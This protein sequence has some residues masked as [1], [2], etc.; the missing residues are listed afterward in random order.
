MSAL[1][2]A[3]LSRSK[4]GNSKTT[5]TFRIRIHLGGA[6]K[7]L[8][9]SGHVGQ[10][11]LSTQIGRC[12]EKNLGVD[13]GPRLS[14]VGPIA[15]TISDDVGVEVLPDGP[16]CPQ[17]NIQPT[18]DNPRV[19]TARRPPASAK[20]KPGPLQ[21]AKKKRKVPVNALA[22]AAAK[23]KLAIRKAAAKHKLHIHNDQPAPK[24]KRLPRKPTTQKKGQQVSSH[25]A[26][27]DDLCDPEWETITKK[28]F[29]AK[30]SMYFSHRSA[31]LA[32]A[33][34]F[35]SVDMKETV[36][37]MSKLPTAPKNTPRLLSVIA[38]GSDGAVITKN[39]GSYV[40]SATLKK[41]WATFLVAYDF[42]PSMVSLICSWSKKKKDQTGHHMQSV[43]C[44]RFVA[45]AIGLS[46][47]YS[48]F[49]VM[50]W[51][52]S[53]AGK[54]EGVEFQGI[55]VYRKLRECLAK[56][57]SEGSLHLWTTYVNQCTK[58][59]EDQGVDNIYK[60]RNGSSVVAKTHTLMHTLHMEVVC[61]RATILSYL[62]WC[63][64]EANKQFKLENPRQDPKTDALEWANLIFAECDIE[65]EVYELCHSLFILFR[66]GVGSVYVNEILMKGF[67]DAVVLASNPVKNFPRGIADWA[68]GAA[69]GDNSV[70]TYAYLKDLLTDLGSVK[71]GRWN[72]GFDK[73]KELEEKL[74]RSRAHHAHFL[75]EQGA[76][77]RPPYWPRQQI[78]GHSVS[79]ETSLL[80]EAEQREKRERPSLEREQ[81]PESIPN[82]DQQMPESN[83]ARITHSLTTEERQEP[84]DG[85][86]PCDGSTTPA[87]QDP[88][89]SPCSLPVGPIADDVAE[90]TAESKTATGTEPMKLRPDETKLDETKLDSAELFKLFH[91]CR[92]ATD[93]QMMDK[94]K[95]VPYVWVNY[96]GKSPLTT[97]RLVMHMSAMEF[98][99]LEKLGQNFH[100]MAYFDRDNECGT[101]HTRIPMQASVVNDNYVVLRGGDQKF[102]DFFA[103]ESAP[104]I[105]L[106]ALIS[107][108]IS[109]Q[110]DNPKTSDSSV[111]DDGGYRVELGCA[112]QACEYGNVPKYFCNNK[113]FVEGNR[114]HDALKIGLGE[115]LDQMQLCLDYTDDLLGN[116]RHFASKEREASYAAKFRK[117][118]KAKWF[119]NE[120]VSIQVK[121]LDRMDTTNSHQDVSN[122]TWAG[123]DRTSSLCFVVLDANGKRW[124]VKIITNSRKRIGDHLGSL[125][126]Y[127][128]LH[129][130]ANI[131][132][133]KIDLS[134][135][136]YRKDYFES[137]GLAFPEGY[138]LTWKR[139][140]LI[141]LDD[142]CKYIEEPLLHSDYKEKV[143][144][145]VEYVK[146]RTAA[147]TR[148][149]WLSGPVHW[150]YKWRVNRGMGL[151][152]AAALAWSAVY[153][154]SFHRFWVVMPHVDRGGDYE[155]VCGEMFGKVTGG[156][157]ARFSP[158][159][160]NSIE[161]MLK[162]Q[163]ITATDAKE[164]KKKQ[165]I[166]RLMQLLFWVR[167]FGDTCTVNEFK[168]QIELAS[169]D[170][171]K[172]LH[173]A[174][175][176]PFRLTIFIQLMVLSGYIESG[177]GVLDKA[178]PVEDRGSYKTMKGECKIP[179]EQM[180]TAM[181]LL[182]ETL[183][184]VKFREGAIENL[185]CEMGKN[186]KV[187]SDYL[188]R[189]S[190]IFMMR[191]DGEGRRRPWMKFYGTRTWMAVSANNRV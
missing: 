101:A 81:L 78:K 9:R 46:S 114:E 153:Q 37:K 72:C 176:G 69:M 156:T 73:K 154:P 83:L 66:K 184:I 131:Y 179:P 34:A 189:G 140:D 51:S 103:G 74:V 120:W 42:P 52:W 177:G 12:E 32:L 133:K 160:S 79:K 36:E 82:L 172:I 38:N 48:L 19:V 148:D 108:V 135:A 6:L 85:A 5:S 86:A 122:C 84:L 23:R 77:Q 175:L 27:D 50:G 181:Y 191:D 162:D 2:S 80:L 112:G 92:I 18:C 190:A 159:G 61:I 89:R 126:C 129:Q 185:A 124:S 141:L 57:G 67:R 136:Q 1:T 70:G 25:A 102:A 182:S 41:L 139:P 40:E 145:T 105:D 94:L 65:R 60:V 125:S 157:G 14:P 44:C 21:N 11:R 99:S 165:V 188:Y 45:M 20:R 106:G 115:V 39:S 63:P 147:T 143:V 76:N 29:H 127:T 55:A 158:C 180:A 31:R 30:D 16:H 62:P 155:K 144:A 187:V 47:I 54:W 58:K 33:A 96:G 64:T 134:Y 104:R 56:Y 149:L 91:G 152:E 130:K 87:P 128:H 117:E 53:E 169:G 151:E 26:D 10:D 43:N 161:E 13:N 173:K 170:I 111:R 146:L 71:K 138:M 8:I 113:V 121:Q 171:H 167:D 7:K 174:Q 178:Y 107:R 93:E 166:D 168:E 123:Y 4:V 116:P 118:L 15:P 95:H 119:R 132:L 186:R 183:G 35:S 97:N 150:F 49:D 17:G 164:L 24:R 3:S 88:P 109:Y 110:Q 137:T 163:G 59:M 98:Y 22:F 68:I 142:G 75:T 90:I 100:G 28:V